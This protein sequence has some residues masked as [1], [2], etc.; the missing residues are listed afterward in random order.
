MKKQPAPQ[1]PRPKPPAGLGEHTTGWQMFAPALA[2]EDWIRAHL[3][4]EDGYLH[5]PDHKHL[6]GA[7]FR[8]LWAAGGFA[9]KGRTVVGTAE[10]VA[11]R[12]NAWQR[13]RQEQQMQ[14]WF[15]RVPDYL[16]TLAADYASQCSDADFC[17]LVEHELYHV[18]QVRDGYGAPVFTK[19]GNPKLMIRGHDVEEF[20]GVVRRYGVGSAAGA[21][22]EL[23]RVAQLQ[24][25]VSRL[26]LAHACGTCSI[27]LVA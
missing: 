14:E 3:L 25:E 26:N 6:I 19:E 5:N 8:V 1:F 24:P 7:E 27:R 23:V 10:Q 11:F 2:V 16:I 15:G 9:S 22:A 4:A 17:A 18:A 21:T 12:C 20:V 13:M